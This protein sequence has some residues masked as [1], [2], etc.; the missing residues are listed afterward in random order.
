MCGIYLG[1]DWVARPTPVS[2]TLP[3]CCVFSSVGPSCVR[4]SLFIFPPSK[5]VRF[6][7]VPSLFFLFCFIISHMWEC[8]VDHLV[9]VSSVLFIHT[10]EITIF[11]RSPLFCFLPPPENKQ[12]NKHKYLFDKFPSAR[13]KQWGVCW[14]V[15]GSHGIGAQC[16]IHLPIFSFLIWSCHVVCSI[17]IW[18]TS[19]ENQNRTETISDPP[20]PGSPRSCRIIRRNVRVLLLI[21]FTFLFCFFFLF[22][23]VFICLLL[24]CVSGRIQYL[25]ASFLN[26]YLRL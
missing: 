7:A 12:T 26:V 21:W 1:P 3:S 9:D 18:K 8:R 17:D 15:S 11:S 22:L 20:P 10:S 19:A 23:L 6:V 25:L 14:R 24:C 4:L 16:Y 5:T 2:T 13:A